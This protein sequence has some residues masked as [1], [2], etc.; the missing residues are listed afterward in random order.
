MEDIT[1][2]D[3]VHAK[4]VC[5]N[6]ERE[7]HDLYVQRDTLLLADVFEN[8]QNMCLKIYELDPARFLTVRDLAQQPALKKTK[9]KLDL[10]T[11]IVMLLMIEKDISGGIWHSIYQHAKANKTN[12]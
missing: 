2:A 12:T 1:D 11:D 4:K 7:Y 10:S 3:F 5:R 6:F 9:A 8:F